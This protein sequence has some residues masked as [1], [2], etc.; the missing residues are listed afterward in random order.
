MP[1]TS[2]LNDPVQKTIDDLKYSLAKRVP[3]M[4]GGFMIQTMYGDILIDP[5]LAEAFR[6]LAADVL[7]NQLNKLIRL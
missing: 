3:N 5:P 7:Q 2:A 6:N 4:M 1:T